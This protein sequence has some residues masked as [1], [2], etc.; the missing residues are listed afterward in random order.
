MS[1]PKRIKP[2]PRETIA[3]LFDAALV[4]LDKEKT[5]YWLDAMEA[6]TRLVELEHQNRL[7]NAA[8]KPE[9]QAGR[10][11]MTGEPYKKRMPNYG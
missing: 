10:S 8:H 5:G 6:Y 3:D 9:T 1:F 11:P 7:Y 2:L 4:G